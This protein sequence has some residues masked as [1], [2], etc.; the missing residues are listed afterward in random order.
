[1]HYPHMG[2]WLP[3]HLAISFLEWRQMRRITP[4]VWGLALVHWPLPTSSVLFGFPPSLF[5][6]LQNILLWTV[7]SATRP[8]AVALLRAHSFVQ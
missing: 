5:P 7:A 6:F 3:Q 2:Q 4:R 8:T 1:M